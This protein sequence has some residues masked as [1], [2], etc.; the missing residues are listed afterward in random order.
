[1][2]ERIHDEEVDT[3]QQMVR[4]LLSEQCPEWS[5]LPLTYMR[6]SGTSNAIWRMEVPGRPDL[7]VR[8]PRTAGAAAGVAREIELLP[9]L[10]ETG[11]ADMVALPTV[12]HS[13]TASGGFPFQWAVLNWIAGDDA[14]SARAD[15][16]SAMPELAV[17]LAR[18]VNEIS[19]LRS[20]PAPE[21]LPGDRG[22][23]VKDLLAR[24]DGWLKD[25]AWSAE[26]L[27]DVNAVR[28]S[29]AES[30][31]AG[32]AEV[33][34]CFVHGDLIPGNLLTV[35]RRLSAVIDWGGAGHADPA[36]DLG[37]AWAVLDGPSR[38]LFRSIVDADDATW[39]RARAFE[40]E[41]AVGA[42]LYYAPRNHLLADVMRRTLGRILEE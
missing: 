20:M 19:L 5:G 33:E 12:Q 23:P 25:P 28:R 9:R 3:S 26:E 30:A 7:V 10:A 6:T 21:R 2:I 14:W 13:G 38:K 1:M 8:L 29:A 41:H 37:L 42:V 16:E 32:V 24:L 39:L 36:Q 18:I 11:L 4:D 17:D 27:V 34:H 35:N 15:L 22:G 31:E 40:L